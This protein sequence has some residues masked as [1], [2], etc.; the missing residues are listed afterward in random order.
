[1]NHDVSLNGSLCIQNSCVSK[2]VSTSSRVGRLFGATLENAFCAHWVGNCSLFWLGCGAMVLLTRLQG[3]MSSVM[4][5][6][7][8]CEKKRCVWAARAK[9][10]RR[11]FL[12][13]HGRWH[14]KPSLFC[15][16]IHTQGIQWFTE[17]ISRKKD[18]IICTLQNKKM[19]I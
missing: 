5:Y 10:N 19:L 9:V 3:Q 15:S 17:E 8:R 1:M 4:H 18:L 13:A 7:C 14:R 11:C 6:T 12:A 2:T 16:T